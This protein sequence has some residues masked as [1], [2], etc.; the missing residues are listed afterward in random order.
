MTL[1]IYPQIVIAVSAK[2]YIKSY[3]LCAANVFAKRFFQK[4]LTI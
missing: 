2:S 3:I 1:K 4:F